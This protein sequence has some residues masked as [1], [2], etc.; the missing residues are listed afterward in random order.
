MSK[1]K[2]RVR[3]DDPVKCIAHSSRTGNPCK[4]PP[5][6]GGNVCRMHGGAAAQVR[7]RAAERIALASDPAAA[8]LIAFM[9]DESVPHNVRLAAAKDLLDRAQVS[10]KTTVEIEVPAWQQILE[11]VVASV[12]PGVQMRPFAEA[13]GAPDPLVVAA[14]RVEAERELAR[15]QAEP[16][17][18][19]WS[20]AFAYGSEPPRPAPVQEPATPM[21]N[22]ADRPPP[23][24]PLPE[25]RRIEPD[26]PDYWAVPRTYRPTPRQPSKGRIAGRRR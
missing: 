8:K 2:R 6:Q 24:H 3:T 22:G 18:A 14:E 9:N 20:D 10:G 12:E 21:R 7:R 15:Y 16:H 11:G 1:K 17:D 26:D 4:N 25:R 5:M 19:D 23:E 13:Q